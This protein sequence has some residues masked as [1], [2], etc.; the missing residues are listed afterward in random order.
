MYK[1]V[2]NLKSTCVLPLIPL[3]KPRGASHGGIRFKGKNLIFFI[4][5]Q[6]LKNSNF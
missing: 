4:K 1:M 5:K 6:S 2:Q 3:N